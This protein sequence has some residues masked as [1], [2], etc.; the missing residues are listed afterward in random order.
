MNEWQW[1]LTGMGL[2]LLGGL[3]LGYWR[4]PSR[5]SPPEVRHE[6]DFPPL[7]RELPPPPMPILAARQVDPS[8]GE[9]ERLELP[10]PATA[11]GTPARDA[12]KRAM[13]QDS[14]AAESV[15]EGSR[16]EID[17]LAQKLGVA[18][19]ARPQRD[20]VAIVH[21]PPQQLFT[22]VAILEHAHAL[23]L[24]LTQNGVLHFLVAGAQQPECVV[25][26][27]QIHAPG[28]FQLD[29]IRELRTPGLLLHLPLPGPLPAVDSVE[30]FARLADAFTQRLGGILCDDQ[31]Q[32]V[33]DLSLW[34]NELR[35][36]AL[37]FD[38]AMSAWRPP[39]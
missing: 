21:A 12:L 5:P 24:R 18:P 4:R 20:V 13:G 9:S 29:K 37:E 3:L 28:N 15:V 32:P 8:P 16:G 19:K 11:S 39:A 2:L 31:Q 27:G 26:I 1:A 17:R 10:K 36:Q 25:R 6:P 7:A 22:G 34:L 38:R 23:Q 14:S 35:H 33:T 30:H